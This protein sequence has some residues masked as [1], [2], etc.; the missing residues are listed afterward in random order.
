M[1][2]MQ[3]PRYDDKTYMVM[4]SFPFCVEK[5]AR[6]I[7]LCSPVFFH[8]RHESKHLLI[9]LIL[10]ELAMYLWRKFLADYLRAC[11]KRGN[12]TRLRSLNYQQVM[13]VSLKRQAKKY[14]SLINQRKTPFFRSK[15]MAQANK[16]TWSFSLYAIAMRTRTCPWIH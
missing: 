13:F 3:I 10:A 14:C 7:C 9:P 16:A 2:L 6:I 11:L 8:D 12:L 5:T 1:L 4:L 15:S